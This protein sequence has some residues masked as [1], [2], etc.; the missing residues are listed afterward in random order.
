MQCRSLITALKTSSK[1]DTFFLI[2]TTRLIIKNS[3]RTKLVTP[4][5][6]KY[7]YLF[8]QENEQ[9]KIKDITNKLN[10]TDSE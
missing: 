8:S 7:V 1:K 5:T 4:N 3:L 9:K 2:V 10:Q 6:M